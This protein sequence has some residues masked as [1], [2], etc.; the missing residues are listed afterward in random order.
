MEPND[1]LEESQTLSSSIHPAE[2]DVELYEDVEDKK[3]FSIRITL[4]L[5]TA[6]T[7]IG[8]IA[9][10]VS[11]YTHPEQGRVSLLDSI[12]TQDPQS[13]AST[14]TVADVL[15]Q[16]NQ[17]NL[18][19]RDLIAQ[20]S[21]STRASST[22]LSSVTL[23]RDTFAPVPKKTASS[24]LNGAAS[25]NIITEY[26]I[27]ATSSNSFSTTTRVDVLSATTISK[28]LGVSFKVDPYWQVTPK[29]NTPYPTVRIAK[30]GPR[31]TDVIT[32][33]R[34]SGT[35]VSTEDS[36]NGNVMYYYDSNTQLWM[37]LNY[38]N[39]TPI[40][41]S[42]SATSF[43]PT[44]FTVNQKPILKGTTPTKTLIVALNTNDFIIVN[45]SGSGYSSILNEFVKNIR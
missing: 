17:D 1:Q 23:N 25:K 29:W 3:D 33:T 41:Q 16:Q 22:A 32:M 45:I 20:S 12:F 21:S 8:A 31:A 14:S 5:I 40:N 43:T 28:D 15:A 27:R 34:F 18:A 7:L 13:Y 30:V 26:I 37:T 6:L 42:L 10:Y 44:S 36:I 19:R 24:N 11:K 2:E 9:F 4:M 35:S 38:T 39:S